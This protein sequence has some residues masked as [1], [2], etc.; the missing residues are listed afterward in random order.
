MLEAIQ[1]LDQASIIDDCPIGV[2]YDPI[3]CSAS[4]PTPEGD[5][6]AGVGDWIVLNER[7]QFEVL[8]ELSFRERYGS[9]FE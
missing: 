3:T 9:V 7:L 6:L 5:V 1:I 4:V 2:I 8:S